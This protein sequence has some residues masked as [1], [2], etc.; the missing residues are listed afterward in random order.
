MFSKRTYRW[1][2]Q[3]FLP[4]T[5]AFRDTKSAQA[6]PECVRGSLCNIDCADSFTDRT[7]VNNEHKFAFYQW[8]LVP[9]ICL[10]FW[11]PEARQHYV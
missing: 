10:L 5:D 7:D 11:T 3:A 9:N 4:G 8:T 2:L 1:K 6:R